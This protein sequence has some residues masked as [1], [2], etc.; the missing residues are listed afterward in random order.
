MIHPHGIPLEDEDTP[1]GAAYPNPQPGVW[2]IAVYEEYFSERL[3]N[4]YDLKATVRHAAFARGAGSSG[5]G[6]PP[7]GI[8]C[9][10]DMRNRWGTRRIFPHPPSGVELAAAQ[11]R[12]HRATVDASCRCDCQRVHFPTG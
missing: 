10:R 12:S 9:V 4:A 2:E 7:L 3:D 5:D 11:G 8:I 1:D 6:R